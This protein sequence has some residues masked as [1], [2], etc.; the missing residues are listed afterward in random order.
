[1]TI[2]STNVLSPLSSG[3]MSA[4]LHRAA[5]VY[6]CIRTNEDAKIIQIVKDEDIMEELLERNN[7]IFNILRRQTFIQ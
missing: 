2:L 4:T 3:S 6:S 5:N 7:S 1:M